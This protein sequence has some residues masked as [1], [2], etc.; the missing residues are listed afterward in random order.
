MVKKVASIESSIDKNAVLC[1]ECN[2]VLI[3][4]YGDIYCRSARG[5]QVDVILCKCGSEIVVKVDCD[6]TEEINCATNYI[7][8]GHEYE[9][10]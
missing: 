3:Y 5:F 1:K 6:C 8:L 4:G 2:S 10:L 7:V 9:K